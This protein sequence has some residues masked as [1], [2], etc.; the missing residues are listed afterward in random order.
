MIKRVPKALRTGVTSNVSAGIIGM[1]FCCANCVSGGGVKKG[2]V[3]R[4]GI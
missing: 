1:I 2:R 3:N 4:Y